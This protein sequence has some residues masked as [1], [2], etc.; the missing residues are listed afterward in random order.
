[1]AETPSDF[2]RLMER[3]RSGCPEAAR[4]IFDLYSEAVRGVVRRTLHQRMRRQY[5]SIDFVQSVW[6][7]FFTVPAEAYT[8]TSPEELVQFLSQVA[9]NKVTDATR[10]RMNTRKRNLERERFLDGEEDDTD[11]L[12][13]L[14]PTRGPTPSQVAIAEESWEQLLAGQ[15]PHHRRLLE[16]RLAGH[17]YEE[18]AQALGLHPKVI[19]RVLKQ[20]RRKVEMP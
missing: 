16:L 19:Q 3:V 13:D 20:L 5:D 17:T 4:E 11:E 12:V 7:S 8:F 6:A 15:P 18:I 10:L 9:F 1:M 14:L 2:K